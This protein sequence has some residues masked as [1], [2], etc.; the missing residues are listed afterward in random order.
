M[1][2]P[3]LPDIDDIRVVNLL[4]GKAGQPIRCTL[5]TTEL[6]RHGIP[7]RA[8]SYAWGDWQKCKS[9]PTIELDGI[10]TEVSPNLHSALSR[11]RRADQSV[12]LWVDA[13]CIDQGKDIAALEERAQQVRMMD[14]IF[15]HAELVYCDLG[16]ADEDTPTLIETLQSC[17]HIDFEA[18]NYDNVDYNVLQK[19]AALP[20]VLDP[21][22]HAFANFCA[23]PYFSRLWVLQEYTLARHACILVGHC[24]LNSWF[25]E[26][27]LFV[28]K[29]FHSQLAE[30]CWGSEASEYERDSELPKSRRDLQTMTP[31]SE[32][33]GVATDSLLQFAGSRR[34]R[35]SD[36]WID[37]D[38]THYLVRTSS[39]FETTDPRDKIYAILG[40]LA[41]Q[42]IN[43]VISQARAGLDPLPLGWARTRASFAVS[44]TESPS[45]V[46]KRLALHLID[47]GQGVF[48]ISRC[49]GQTRDSPSWAFSLTKPGPDS[50]RIFIQEQGLCSLYK[51]C[52][53]S[54]L[55]VAVEPCGS[56][57]RMSG[58]MMGTILSRS[59]PC[60]FASI[61]DGG[62]MVTQWVAS[63]S[64]SICN[65]S[66]KSPSSHQTDFASMCWTAAIGDCCTIANKG[67]VR[68]RHNPGFR[69]TLDAFIGDVEVMS[70]FIQRR[71]F[72]ISDKMTIT[73]L[74]NGMSEML[75]FLGFSL[76]RRLAITS[77]ALICSVP[78]VTQHGDVV[79]IFC[80]MPIPFVLRP[81][82]DAYSIIGLCY[83]HGM[84]DGQAFSGGDASPEILKIC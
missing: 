64:T 42:D 80:G 77:K 62:Q 34:E 52:G 11:I 75:R 44:Y 22:W 16:D 41:R 69:K 25:M 33:I 72:T 43:S 76:G 26:A 83:V 68:T 54:K 17:K 2:I 24:E 79:G 30:W 39:S 28:A 12:Y 4:L 3:L 38:L 27:L 23:R 51:A 67:T 82:G 31:L 21:F 74:I 57:L 78:G 58:L 84:M 5:E 1:V 46:S 70:S 40:L 60:P 7:Y 13:L 61:P 48:A 35:L 73:N 66:G 47:S 29:Y 18:F 56:L 71:G 14:R 9:L 10:K 53:S 37:R 55:D 8:L 81:E 15:S 45:E 20:G 50:M 36:I 49:V 6:S 65:K 32:P 63:V 19:V 59:E